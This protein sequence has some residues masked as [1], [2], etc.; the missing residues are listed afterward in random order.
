M[1]RRS[2]KHLV[3]ASL[4]TSAVVVQCSLTALKKGVAPLKPVPVPKLEL[5]AA[6]ISLRLSKSVEDEVKIHISRRVFGHI[7]ERLSSINYY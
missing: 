1:P 4:N 3:D 2:A 7:Q 6:V 5:I